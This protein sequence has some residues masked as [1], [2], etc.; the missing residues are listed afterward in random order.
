[1]FVWYW[2]VLHTLKE[3]REDPFPFPNFIELVDNKYFT[4]IDSVIVS[5]R[6][7]SK[8]KILK[9]KNFVSNT[10]VFTSRHYTLK[11]L[12]PILRESLQ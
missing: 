1:M 2:L 8:L 11:S 5:K 10:I 6:I 7:H 12:G 4:K 3:Q 9:K